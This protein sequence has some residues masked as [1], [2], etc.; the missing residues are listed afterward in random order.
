MLPFTIVFSIVWTIMLLIW[1]W[2]GIQLVDG[3]LSYTLPS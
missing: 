1:F 2:L 3:H